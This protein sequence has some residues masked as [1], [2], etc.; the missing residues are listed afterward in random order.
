[1][2]MYSFQESS[3]NNWCRAV[4]WYYLSSAFSKAEVLKRE[5][6]KLKN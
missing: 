6:E 3:L 1:M 5:V 4:F 2:E